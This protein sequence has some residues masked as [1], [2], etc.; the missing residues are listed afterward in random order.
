MRRFCISIS[1]VA[2][3]AA[4]P[5]IFAQSSAAES[6][7]SPT[8]TRR[9]VAQTSASPVIAPRL[10]ERLAWM[11]GCWAYRDA[12][13]RYVEEQWSVPRAGVM[14]GYSRTT[15]SR[16][17]APGDTLLLYETTRIYDAPD[18][19]LVFA[20]SPSGQ[21]PDEFRWRGDAAG[22][23]SAVT[24]ENPG[25]D[26]PQRVSYRRTAGASRS[27]S[28]QGDSLVARVEGTRNGAV[29]GIDFPYARTNCTM[30]P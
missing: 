15:R 1:V 19:A 18:G 8:A 6:V 13:G 26:F 27:S 30:N 23:D 2:F 4:A 21:R 28:A 12:R 16:A 22:L 14:F 25:H 29:R 5:S 17:G 7:V 10:T 24:F 3:I 20:A 9:P 11:T